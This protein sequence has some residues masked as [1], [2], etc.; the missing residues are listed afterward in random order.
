MKQ[1]IIAF[2]ISLLYY[3]IWQ[4]FIYNPPQKVYHN[5]TSINTNIQKFQQEYKKISKKSTPIQRDQIF[6]ILKDILAKNS[7]QQILLNTKMD[8]ILTT[9][10]EKQK[11]KNHLQERFHLSKEFINE[12]FEKNRIVWDWINSISNYL[13]NN[14]H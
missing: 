14:F 1:V 6:L 2:V 11:F 8:Q 5:L 13:E 12:E 3:I 7:N 9:K 10:I 4:N